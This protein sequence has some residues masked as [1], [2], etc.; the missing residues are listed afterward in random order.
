MD[1]FDFREYTAQLLEDSEVFAKC[2][3]EALPEKADRE[4]YWRV[5]L[6]ESGMKP[7]AIDALVAR[8]DC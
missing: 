1:D 4:A 7:K 2:L 5:A 6:A 3:R 8:M